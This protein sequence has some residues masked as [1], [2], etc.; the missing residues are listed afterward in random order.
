MEITVAG[1]NVPRG[2]AQGVLLVVVCATDD[3][4][5][6]VKLPIVLMPGPKR[7]MFSS[8]AAAKKGVKTIIKQ[9]GSTLAFSVTRLNSMEYL[10][11]II[12]KASRRPESA[13]CAIPEKT[14]RNEAVLTIKSVVQPVGSIKVDQKVGGKP[15]VEDQN[16]SLADK[17]QENTNKVSYSE[18]IENDQN[19]LDERITSVS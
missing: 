11:L 5:R 8:S 13:L 6:T 4:L 16:K 3:A 10:D 2:T 17:I 18:K 15:V 12:A 14:F 1:D 7:N 19:D 9:K